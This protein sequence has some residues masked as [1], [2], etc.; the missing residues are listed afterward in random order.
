M[1]RVWQWDTFDPQEELE[2]LLQAGLVD[3]P[4]VH[5][6]N[7]FDFHDGMR[8]IVSQ[9]KYQFGTFLHVSGSVRGSLMKKFCRSSKIDY[10]GIATAVHDR[11]MFLSGRHVTL[12][13][14]HGPPT[15][16]FMV[17]HCFDPPLPANA[18]PADGSFIPGG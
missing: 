6:E 1:R 7:V 9:D 4:G 3:R 17:A 2:K 12:G 18:K 5:R 8:L 10:M 15:R 11:V 13:Y 14:F 16:P